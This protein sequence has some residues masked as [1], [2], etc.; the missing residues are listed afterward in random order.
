MLRQRSLHLALAAVLIIFVWG[1]W[2]WALLG[3]YVGRPF[4]LFTQSDFPAVTIVSRMVSEG[5][6]AE[7]YSLD[8]QVEGQRRLI[9]EG[10][11]YLSP[12]DDLKYPYPYA[13]FIA[14]LMSPLSDI[15][16]T[17]AWAVWDLTNLAGMAL[18]L[19]YLLSSLSLSKNARLV[20]MLGGLT[21]LPFVVNLEQ[22]QSSG[23]VMLSLGL[24]I[25]LLKKGKDLPA[26]LALGLLALKVQ[27]LPFILLVLA[28]K[29][30][31]RA[32]A[33]MAATA[34]M[35]LLIT[36][37]VMGFGWVSGYVDMLG[38][39]QR[40]AREL[41][42]DPW[43]SHSLAGGLAALFGGGTDDMIRMMNLTAMV[44]AAALLL[45]VW[46]GQWEPRVGRWDGAMALTLLAAMLTNPQMNTHDLCLL[47]VPGAL[48]LAYLASTDIASGRRWAIAWC[49]TLWT[50][51]VAT[52]LF[53]PQVFTAPV[54]LTTLAMIVM[55]WLLLRSFLRQSRNSPAQPIPS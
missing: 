22:G 14:V 42:L 35:L 9:A 30:R 51:Y 28:W 36:G 20:L 23:V 38:R 39:A 41:L 48:G 47:A 37:S 13:P 24:G 55:G 6:G 45:W 26:G 40:Y 49:A 18:G 12:D 17:V 33:G 19:W 2:S 3:Q 4:G 43:Y 46:K 50:A 31:W 32:L 25:G 5:H 10:Y 53:L 34:G 1:A 29:R 54:R 44:G 27:W 7:L 15:A 21:S 52:A 11:L 8:A 16:P